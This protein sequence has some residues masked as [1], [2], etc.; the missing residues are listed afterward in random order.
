MSEGYTVD[1]GAVRGVVSKF[2]DPADR[3]EDVGKALEAA[4]ESAGECWGDDEA[5]KAFAN[6]YL[7]CVPDTTKFFAELAKGIRSLKKSVETAMDDYDK[8]EVKTLK[9]MPGTELT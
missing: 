7:P 5:G 9:S 6:D 1:T 2:D 4:L 3:L 8:H